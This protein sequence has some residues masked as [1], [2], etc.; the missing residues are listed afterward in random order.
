M[1][2]GAAAQVSVFKFSKTYFTLVNIGDF[3]GFVFYRKFDK[4]SA[5]ACEC[6]NQSVGT[7]R[8]YFWKR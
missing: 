7:Y 1:V 2:G 8:K 6:V 5:E 4:P 3:G